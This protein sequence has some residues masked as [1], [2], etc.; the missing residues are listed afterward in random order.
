MIYS[1]MLNFKDFTAGFFSAVLR[2][3]G[4]DLTVA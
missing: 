2:L 4:L 1:G 3:L